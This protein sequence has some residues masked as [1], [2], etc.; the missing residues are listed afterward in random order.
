M[1]R[2]HHK[3]HGRHVFKAKVAEEEGANLSLC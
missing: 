3:L 2:I 1:M